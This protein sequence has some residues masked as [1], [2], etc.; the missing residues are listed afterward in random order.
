MRRRV[1]KRM[2]RRREK[3]AQRDVEGAGAARGAGY[4]RRGGRTRARA[5]PC[6]EQV[7]TEPAGLCPAHR[8]PHPILHYTGPGLTLLHEGRYKKQ[9]Y[10]CTRPARRRPVASSQ[11]LLNYR[12][13]TEIVLT[14]NVTWQRDR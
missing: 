7:A 3:R 12:T 11:R 13:L 1:T 9:F 6:G 14:L 2:S 4:G 5:P 8:T 10:L